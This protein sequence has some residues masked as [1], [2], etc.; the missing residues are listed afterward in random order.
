M[1]EK[2]RVDFSKGREKR[3]RALALPK[4]NALKPLAFSYGDTRRNAFRR[5]N[6]E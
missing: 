5:A 6:M 4:T 3:Q 2:E 1:K